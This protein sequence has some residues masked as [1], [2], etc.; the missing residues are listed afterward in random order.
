LF[1]LNQIELLRST[2]PELLTRRAPWSMT[3]SETKL[4][5]PGHF[6]PRASGE[7]C[8]VR[9]SNHLGAGGARLSQPQRVQ[10]STIRGIPCAHQPILPAAGGDTRAPFHFGNTP[11]ASNAV[12]ARKRTR[13]GN[14]AEQHSQCGEREWKVAFHSAV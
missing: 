5:N 13:Q 9:C 14:W 4:S 8:E 6:L 2:E 3:I 7:N 10:Q 1:F 12:A 11:C